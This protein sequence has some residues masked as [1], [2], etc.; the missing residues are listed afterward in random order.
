[1]S[2]PDKNENKKRL[3]VG[4][5][6]ASGIIFGIRMLEILKK[7]D[8]ETHLIVSKA[9][10]MTLAYETDMKLKDLRE[11]AHEFHPMADIG[12]N[13][14]SGSYKTLGMVIVPCSI[15]TMSEISCGVTGSLMSRA[16]DV[17]LKDRRRLVLAIR[18]TPLHTGH[19]RTM[20]QLSEMGAIIAPIMPAFYNRPK[21]LDDI[22]DHTVG[23][24]LDLFDI[25]AHLVKRWKEEDEE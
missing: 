12:A 1:V 6:G 13:I 21:T 10:E 19:L 3:I 22:I 2:K 4:I 17:V 7:L 16:A 23:R 24:L 14:S 9:A 15:R 11:M 8:I 5:S 18:E 20:T 25:D